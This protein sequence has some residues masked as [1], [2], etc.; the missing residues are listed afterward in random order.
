MQTV[1]PSATYINTR[2]ENHDHDLVIACD[3]IGAKHAAIFVARLCRVP[4]AALL[5]VIERDVH[6]FGD[7]IPAITT[8]ERS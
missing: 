6:D 2:R 4:E 7:G 5:A 1:L 3:R 8:R